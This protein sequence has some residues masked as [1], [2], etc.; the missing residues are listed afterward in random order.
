MAEGFRDASASAPPR[1][2]PVLLCILEWFQSDHAMYRT[3]STAIGALKERFRLIGISLRGASDET[4][5]AIFD[6]V[7]VLPSPGPLLETVR[8]AA[9]IAASEKPDLVYYPS[10]G[11]FPETIFLINL[12]LAPL[13]MMSI[14]HP[15]T[16]HSPFIDY[17]IVEEDYLGD[18]ACF[19]EKLLSVPPGAIPYRPP[20][21]CPV[22][23]SKVR[24]SPDPVRIAVAASLMKVNPLLLETL[25]RIAETSKVP[26]EFHF[27]TL[28]A[29]GLT[30]VY[31]ENLVRRILGSRAIVFPHSSY[32]QYVEN[33]NRC[34]MFANPFPFGN[35]NG[36][37]DTIRQGLPGVCLSGREVHSHIDEGLFRR[38]GL[39]EWL[40]ARTPDEYVSAAV[41][42]AEN[43][44][45][46][47]A[48]ARSLLRSNPDVILFRSRPG[49]FADAIAWLHEN[50]PRLRSEDT[51]VLRP[52]SAGD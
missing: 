19:S 25:R 48:L 18:P 32:A 9:D 7:H 33:L 14:G 28:A 29:F 13:Q 10:V 5:R 1:A 2:K 35:T 44:T 45:E 8:R 26:V 24:S 12:R 39:P 21:N 4:S 3:Y 46:R 16:S 38:L 11:M 6:E 30:K 47:E 40:I 36:I 20:T 43:S 34:D 51:R 31:L 42:L 22:I 17:A 37:V 23:A 52:H 41:R 49:L 27:F 50:H 15:A